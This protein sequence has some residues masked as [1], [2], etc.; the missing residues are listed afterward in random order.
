MAHRPQQRC[1][2]VGFRLC[3]PI[4]DKESR[5]S[6]S[7][8]LSIGQT[9]HVELLESL[10][11]EMVRHIKAAAGL[12]QL[13]NRCGISATSAFRGSTRKSKTFRS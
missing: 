1:F 2:G 3:W 5:Y 7:L 13:Q 6:Q 10:R 12:A 11:D 9:P 8:L 4:R